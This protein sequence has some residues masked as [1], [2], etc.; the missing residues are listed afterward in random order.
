MGTR[1]T[2]QIHFK[3]ANL[4]RD[5]DLLDTVQ[6]V[7]EQIFNETPNAIR[8]LCDRW[9]GVASDYAEV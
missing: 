8:P 2:G 4:A 1:Q 5:V 6:Q 7:G 9:L 3:V